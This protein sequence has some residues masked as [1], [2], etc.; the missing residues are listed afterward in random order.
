MPRPDVDPDSAES[1][2][3]WWVLTET[4]LSNMLGVLGYRVVSVKRSLHRC[5]ARGDEAPPPPA[6]RSRFARR[7][8]EP[9]AT[10]VGMEE[11]STIVAERIPD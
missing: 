9:P 3:A 5:S 1:Y 4:C 11:C 10:Q 2:F 8:P 6:P 7:K